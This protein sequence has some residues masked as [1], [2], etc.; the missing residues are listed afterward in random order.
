MRQLFPFAKQTDARLKSPRMLEALATFQ[1]GLHEPT[2][3][4][5]LGD[6]TKY[7]DYPEPA[8]DAQGNHIDK[9]GLTKPNAKPL[10]RDV[11]IPR[12]IE[13]TMRQIWYPSAAPL[14]IGP[15]VP[16]SLADWSLKER[17]AIYLLIVSEET[18]K[19]VEELLGCTEWFVRACLVKALEEFKPELEVLG[20]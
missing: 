19:G 4:I 13:R 2:F 8:I 1:Q 18:Y 15:M 16:P 9:Y 3:F 6:I 7:V 20:L 17:I 10:W 14:L 11:D 5:D 12:D